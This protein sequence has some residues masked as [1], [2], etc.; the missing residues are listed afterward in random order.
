MAQRKSSCATLAQLRQQI[1]KQALL[2][3]YWFLQD[4]EDYE[5]GV[6]FRSAEKRLVTACRLYRRRL[7]IE[8][9]VVGTLGESVLEAKILDAALRIQYWLAQYKKNRDTQT[10]RELTRAEGELVFA[11]KPYRK[12]LGIPSHNTDDYLPALRRHFK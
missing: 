1:F 10:Y 5:T 12:K 2:M 4:F 8:E 7:R 11:G 6:R 3:H 9:D